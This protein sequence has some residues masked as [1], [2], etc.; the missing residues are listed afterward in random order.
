MGLLFLEIGAVEEMQVVEESEEPVVEECLD[1][2][3]SVDVSNSSSL[4]KLLLADM[5]IKV[6]LVDLKK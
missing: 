1:W 4:L 6:K 2:K 3:E 5:I